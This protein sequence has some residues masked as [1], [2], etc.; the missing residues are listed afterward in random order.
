MKVERLALRQPYA[1][2]V[3]QGIC[4]VYYPSQRISPLLGFSGRD[5]H[6]TALN[7][8]QITRVDLLYIEQ[9]HKICLVGAVYS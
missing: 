2:E 8:N 9:E 4:L 6:N 1:A 5:V 7:L 3:R